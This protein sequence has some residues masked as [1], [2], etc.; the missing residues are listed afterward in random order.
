MTEWK[1]TIQC[2]LS[3]NQCDLSFSA[4]L[5]SSNDYAYTAPSFNQKVFILKFNQASGAT[6][7]AQYMSDQS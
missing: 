2:P 3:D 4:T 6:I 1:N 7:N 5:H